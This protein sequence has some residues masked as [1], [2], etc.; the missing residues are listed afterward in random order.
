MHKKLL[1]LL[2]S[3]S[4][5]LKS[6]QNSHRWRNFTGAKYF[7]LQTFYLVEWYSS[8]EKKKKW[9]WTALLT[10]VRSS[11]LM[12]HKL[13]TTSLNGRVCNSLI[14]FYAKIS[15][16]STYGMVISALE[17]ERILYL[18]KVSYLDIRLSKLVILSKILRGK[19]LKKSAPTDTDRIVSGVYFTV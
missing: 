14:I 18:K 1:L 4:R 8:P 11:L 2:L 16:C 17:R 15:I 7:H 6:A 10:C 5:R 3:Y 12:K 13:P 19:N 9:N